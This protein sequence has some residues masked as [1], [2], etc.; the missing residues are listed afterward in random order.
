M[1][2]NIHIKYC[3]S[4]IIKVI[5][6]TKERWCE[7][8]IWRNSGGDIVFEEKDTDGF[9]DKI[10]RISVDFTPDTRYTRIDSQEKDQVYIYFIPT[11]MI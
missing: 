2:D 10:Y 1:S 5:V 6:N 9:T 8:S 4:G 3:E 7:Y 11:D